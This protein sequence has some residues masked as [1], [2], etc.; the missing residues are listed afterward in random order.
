VTRASSDTQ[1]PRPASRIIAAEALEGVAAFDLAELQDGAARPRRPLTSRDL[2]N[3]TARSAFEMGRKRGYALGVRDG[4]QQGFAHGSQAL[5][6]FDRHQA[7]EIA[8]RMQPLADGFRAG[9]AA[10]ESDLAADL[11]S[12]AVDIA[13]QV[14]RREI[15]SDPQALLPAAREALRSVAE[16][17]SQLQLHVHPDDAAMLTEHLELVR[18]GQCELRPDPAL[19]TGSCRVEA[20]TGVA[21]AGFAQRW[22]AVM[23]SLGR[24]WEQAP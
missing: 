7:C 13:R 2:A 20:D 11:V 6:A 22:Q 16:G 1:E 23:A 15:A 14:L 24:E 17:A 9:V 19:P 4:R 5:A 18:S 21:D 3:E 8:R 12:L 10:L